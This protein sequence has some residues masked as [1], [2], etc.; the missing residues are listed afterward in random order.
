M[1]Y[2]I[3]GYIVWNGGKLL[4]GRKTR[5]AASARNLAIAGVIGAAIAGAVVVGSRSSGD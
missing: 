3:L 5:G 2:K 1:G 4:V